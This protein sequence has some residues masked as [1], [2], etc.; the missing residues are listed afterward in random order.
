M[1]EKPVKQL[2]YDMCTADHWNFGADTAAC[3]AAVDALNAARTACAADTTSTECMKVRDLKN[4]IQPQ[5][6]SSDLCENAADK[7]ACEAEVVVIEGM[8]ADCKAEIDGDATKAGS[9]DALKQKR[10]EVGGKG[11]PLH[12]KFKAPKRDLCAGAADAAACQV[13]VDLLGDMKKLCRAERKGDTTKAG[14]C[15]AYEAKKTELFPDDFPQKKAPRDLCDGAADP[16]ACAAAVEVVKQLQIDCQQENAGD[17]TKGGSCDNL[18]IKRK[19]LMP[20]KVAVTKPIDPSECDDAADNAACLVVLDEIQALRP[21]C[22]AENKGDLT[23]VG[24]CKS[25]N[26]KRRELRPK[27]GF[28]DRCTGVADEAACR[29]KQAEIDNLKDDCDAENNNDLTK[30]GSCASLK[31][32]KKEIKALSQADPC[33]SLAADEIQPCKDAAATIGQ[34]RKDCRTAKAAGEENPQACTDFMAANEKI[35]SVSRT[36]KPRNLCDRLPADQQVACE[37]AYVLVEDLWPK[38]AI[39]KK[40]GNADHQ[41]CLDLATNVALLPARKTK[42]EKAA[43]AADKAANA[44]VHP[45]ETLATPEEVSACKVSYEN[46]KTLKAACIADNKADVANSQNCIDL[47]AALAEPGLPQADKSKKN[48]K[49]A[50]Q[51]GIILGKSLNKR[52]VDEADYIGSKTGKSLSYRR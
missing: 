37:A 49:I 1:G 48:S 23:K 24:S 50:A 26:S 27:E 46:I 34:L 12:E 35:P 47:K 38:C 39:H 3:Q 17:I 30:V 2:T 28:V 25:L 42:E 40:E 19:E 43:E 9:C 51:G 21:D 45:C 10:K 22:I 4:S 7:A 15:D 52:S 8:Q 33:D 18:I 5:K 44:I 31:A 29:A 6:T 41:E 13:N 16:T 20:K 11:N 36:K 32:K 14:S